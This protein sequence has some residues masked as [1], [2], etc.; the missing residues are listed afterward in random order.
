MRNNRNPFIDFIKGMLILGIV[1]GHFVNS[2]SKVSNI[3]SFFHLMIRTFDLPFFMLISGYLLSLTIEK[4]TLRSALIN[5]ISKIARPAFVFGAFF[6]LVTY[7][8]IGDISVKSIIRYIS[9]IWFIWS[10]LICS[11]VV[12]VVT[13]SLKKIKYQILLLCMFQIVF[14][15]L[16]SNPWNINYMFPFFV[17]GF[18]LKSIR[19]HTTFLNSKMLRYC[20]FFTFI[21]LLSEWKES[22]TIWNSNGQ[23]LSNTF[24][25]TVA[26]ALYRF[27][28]GITGCFC[29][30]SIYMMFYNNLDSSFTK[31]VCSFGKESLMIY[32][33]HSFLV[34]QCF[35]SALEMACY[36]LDNLGGG[37]GRSFQIYPDSCCSGFY[38]SY[39]QMHCRN[40]Q[41]A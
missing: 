39:L 23:W 26:I 36:R 27:T 12:I 28:I 22:F 4:Y 17:I 33:V 13:K 24:G 32:I 14:H 11:I 40:C 30:Y 8:V 3:H 31:T 2:F 35:T 34:S 16:P 38:C 21:L 37:I 19:S 1:Y 25:S 18:Y 41:N 10:M 29:A 5:K 9:G 15:L 20:A 6:A 7:A